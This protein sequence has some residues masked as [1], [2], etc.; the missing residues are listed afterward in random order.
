MRIKEYINVSK[1]IED[2]K[3]ENPDSDLFGINK[4]PKK[5][6]RKLLLDKEDELI[7]AENGKKIKDLEKR[8][9]TRGLRNRRNNK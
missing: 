9:H 5:G 3:E 6:I 4:R 7:R 1:F 2:W 8:K